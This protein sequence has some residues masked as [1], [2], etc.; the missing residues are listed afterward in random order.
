MVFGIGTGRCGTVS[1]S[2]F[3]AAQ[4]FSVVTH[5]F[6]GV[7]T[8]QHVDNALWPVWE[9]RPPHTVESVSPHPLAVVDENHCSTFRYCP[10]SAKAKAWGERGGR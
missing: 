1:L 7:V 8:G 5:E 3:L 6:R 4:H 9:P 10:L 2:K